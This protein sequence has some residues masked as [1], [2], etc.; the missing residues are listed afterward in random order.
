MIEPFYQQVI[1][2]AFGLYLALLA[3]AAAC[4]VWKFIIPNLVS[5]A[6]VLLFFATVLMLPFDVT[7]LSHLGAAA[8][9]LVVGAA[10]FYR[11]WMGAGDVKLMTA[12]SLWAGFQHMPVLLFHVCI[13][14]GVFAL[15]MIFL[16][17]L[18]M[19]MMVLQSS[20]G[21]PSLPR[22]LTIGEEIPFG[23]AIVFGGVMLGLEVPYL[24]FYL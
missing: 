6:L 19:G 9:C 20:A 7:W 24:G 23:V 5:V 16:R 22:I 1:Y 15:F 12:L 11:G 17:R 14:G 8:A 3:M 4:D 21:G 2:V 18:V 13:A 10:M